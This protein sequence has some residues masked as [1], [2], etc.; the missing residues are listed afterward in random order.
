MTDKT[1]MY[2]LNLHLRSAYKWKIDVLA[3]TKNAQTATL[4]KTVVTQKRIFNT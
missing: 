1:V 2:R 3:H 4:E